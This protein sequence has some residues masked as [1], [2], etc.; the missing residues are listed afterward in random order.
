M[1]DKPVSKDVTED[2]DDWEEVPAP[3]ETSAKRSPG[4]M[5]S[6]RLS[7]EEADEIRAAAD[8]EGQSVSGLMRKIVLDQ[9]RGSKITVPAS[10]L[11]LGNFSQVITHVELEPGAPVSGEVPSTAGV[12]W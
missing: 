1:T 8:E 7:A 10:T 9:I 2:E 6:V 11:V 5:V 12:S 4:A 3:A